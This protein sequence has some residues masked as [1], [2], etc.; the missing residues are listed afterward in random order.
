MG[1]IWS[2]NVVVGVPHISQAYG[3]TFL[4]IAALLNGGSEKNLDPASPRSSA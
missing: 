2:D 1:R 3:M 4:Y